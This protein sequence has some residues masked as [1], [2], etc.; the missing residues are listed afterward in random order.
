MS[1]YD[2]SERL[3]QLGRLIHPSGITKI[4]NGSRKVD[5]DDLAALA[6]VFEVSPADLLQPSCKTCY[7]ATLQ[8]FTCDTCG[9]SAS[10]ATP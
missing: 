5:V 1:T 6:S 7:G 2:V 8:G 9:R 3:G 10:N 4:E